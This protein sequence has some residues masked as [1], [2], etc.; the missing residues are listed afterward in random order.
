MKTLNRLCF[1]AAV[2]AALGFAGQ[3]LAHDP[4][5]PP[6]LK[7]LQKERLTV[8]GV[9]ADKLDRG[10]KTISPRGQQMQQEAVKIPAARATDPDLVHAGRSTLPPKLQEQRKERGTR[11]EVAPLK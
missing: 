9:T 7:A 3:L 10:I 2:L 5:V 1:A 4:S 6:R 8:A 11:F